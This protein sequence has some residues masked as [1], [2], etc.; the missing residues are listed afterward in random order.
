MHLSNLLLLLQ[1]CSY[2]LTDHVNP[3]GKNIML[4]LG[5]LVYRS[6]L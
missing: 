5:L 1:Y 6:Y 3:E 4:G 2:Q